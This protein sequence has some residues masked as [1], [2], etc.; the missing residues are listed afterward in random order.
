MRTVKVGDHV[1]TCLSA[2]CGHCE[3]CLTGHMSLCTSPDTKREASDE[4]RLSQ[5]S[6]PML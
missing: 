1:I 5:E 6:G 3:Y 4:P 2:F